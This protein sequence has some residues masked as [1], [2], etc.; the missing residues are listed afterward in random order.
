M[1]DS[2]LFVAASIAAVTPESEMERTAGVT[3]DSPR[4]RFPGSLL[5]LPLRVT[6][7]E[8]E[9]VKLKLKWK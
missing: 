6:F 1:S 5:V 3:E 4:R 9:I 2:A 8:R 7:G